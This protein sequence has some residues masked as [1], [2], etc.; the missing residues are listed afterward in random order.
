[1]VDDGTLLSIVVAAGDQLGVD[2]AEGLVEALVYYVR[3]DAFL[4]EVGAPDPPAVSAAQLRRDRT[5]YDSLGPERP[6]VPCRAPGCPRGA[7]AQS[8]FCRA[9]HFEQVKGRPCS[10][11]D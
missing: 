2:S 6:D 7:I 11:S 5:F 3:F 4:P 10:F 1:M 8:V 9:H